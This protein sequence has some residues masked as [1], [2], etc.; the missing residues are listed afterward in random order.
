MIH[1]CVMVA[2]FLILFALLGALALLGKEEPAPNNAP[3]PAVA[4][5][6]TP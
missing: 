6:S 2:A 3:M 4:A 1:Q 5:P